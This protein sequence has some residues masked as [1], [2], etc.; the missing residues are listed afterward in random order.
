[1]QQILLNTDSEEHTVQTVGT[2]RSLQ[3]L[4]P[5]NAWA[6]DHGRHGMGRGGEKTG[7]GRKNEQEKG[8]RYA[9]EKVGAAGTHTW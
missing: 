1:M 5:L 8:N 2:N 6:G 7:E 9:L 3:R 4:L